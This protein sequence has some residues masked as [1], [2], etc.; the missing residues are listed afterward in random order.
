MPLLIN[1]DSPKELRALLDERGIGMRKKYG[2]NFLIDRNARLRLI[3]SLEIESGYR[4]WEIGPGLGAMTGEILSRCA[5][6]CAFEIDTAFSAILRELYG[7]NPA[8]TLVEGD[9]FK[10]WPIKDSS[11]GHEEDLYLLG[12]LPYNIAASLLA[13]FVEKGRFFKRMVITVQKEVAQRIYAK[14]GSPNYSSFS[15]LCSSVYK[16]RPL[17]DIKGSCFFPQPRV[18]SQGIRL[19]LIQPPKALPPLFYPMVRS[20]FSARRKTLKNTLSAFTSSVIMK[21]DV[22][23]GEIEPPEK[24]IRNAA[25]AGDIAVE[26]LHRAGISGNS[27]AETLNNDEFAAL[28][29]ILEE[30]VCNAA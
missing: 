8:F 1:Y 3:D 12:N 7:A 21:A 16:V 6:L 30:I 10:T 11:T 22:F 2:Q 18:D 19:D 5:Q 15:V 26:V 25:L 4:V 24:M 17:F 9:V 20:L 14:S 23:L 13:D 28:A 29:S 27:R